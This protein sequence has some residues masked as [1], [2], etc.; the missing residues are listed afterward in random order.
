MSASPEIARIWLTYK[1]RIISERRLK[2]YALVSHLAL[3][4]YAFLSIVLTIYQNNLAAQLGATAATQASLVISVLTFG[5]SLIIYGFKFEESARTFREC[6]LRMQSIY[7]SAEPDSVKLSEYS[8]ALDHYPNHASRDYEAMLFE[9]WKA[10][11]TLY[12]TDGQP[13]AFGIARILASYARTFLWIAS[14]A[15]IFGG[16]LVIAVLIAT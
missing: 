16:P 13:I 14:L 6:Y 15:I 3:S 5:L 9:T 2:A 10:G 1:T 8:R 12:G 7:Q 11:R 4:W